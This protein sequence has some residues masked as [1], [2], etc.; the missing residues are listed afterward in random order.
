MEKVPTV[1][2]LLL[3]T[4]KI[5]SAPKENFY[6]QNPKKLKLTENQ[7]DLNKKEMQL[8]LCNIF[9]IFVFNE[10]YLFA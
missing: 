6:I 3:K 9:S 2:N 10:L 7:G 1:P 4:L 5:V 8:N